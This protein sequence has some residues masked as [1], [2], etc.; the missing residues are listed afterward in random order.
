MGGAKKTKAAE[1]TPAER[2]AIKVRKM[3]IL[4]AVKL[5]FD[6]IVLQAAA[7]TAFQCVHVSLDLI[8]S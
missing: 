2:A 3:R 8:R 1:Q 6:V 5:Y 7:D 4:T